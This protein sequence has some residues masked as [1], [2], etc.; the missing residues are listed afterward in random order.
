MRW[1]DGIAGALLMLAARASAQGLTAFV[2]VSV[3]TMDRPDVLNHRVI[4]VD[5]GRITQVTP[6]DS[7]IIP[8]G[9]RRI[10]GRGRSYLLPGLVDTHVHLELNERLWIS[11]FL[12][13]GITTVINLRGDERH[14]ALR[15]DIAAGRF[16][17]PT[18]FTAGRYANLPLIASADDA[19]NEARLQKAAGYDLIKTHGNLTGPA[20]AQLAA[21]SRRLGIPLVG[22]AP[23]NL[24]FDSV[25]AV[26]HGTQPC[27]FLQ[28]LTHDERSG[29]PAARRLEV[30]RPDRAQIDVHGV[31]G[32]C[33]N[34]TQ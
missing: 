6:V 32:L 21:E 2:D 15:D 25:I 34:Q 33:F 30:R 10:E 3:I 22:H 5:S 17:G 16:P 23:R 28:H 13:S 12:R 19:T 1:R 8:A 29:T 4:M 14:L 24:A 20:F 7:A 26:M 11:A 9:A 18:I 31:H 27:A